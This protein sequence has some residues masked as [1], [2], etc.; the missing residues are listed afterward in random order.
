MKRTPLTSD[1]AKTAAWQAKSRAKGLRRTNRAPKPRSALKR[2]TALRAR[3]PKRR[4]T[5]PANVWAAVL[6]RDHSRCV[7]CGNHVQGVGHPHHLLPRQEWPQFN[8][9][10]RAIVLMDPD[11]HM[12]HEFSPNDRL[13]WAALPDECQEFLRRVAAVDARAARLIRTR[14]P[15]AVL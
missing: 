7:W 1:P 9:E 2:S 8:G 3:R 4:M 11:C 12:Q 13:P 6:L 15:G 10:R 5:T 14:Y